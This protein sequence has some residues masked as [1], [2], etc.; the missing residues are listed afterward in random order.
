MLWDIFGLFLNY[1]LAY[2]HLRKEEQGFVPVVPAQM[3]WRQG[4]A[5]VRS[6]KESWTKT[7]RK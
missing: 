1:W 2:R 5:I 3:P 4:T 6:T 7:M